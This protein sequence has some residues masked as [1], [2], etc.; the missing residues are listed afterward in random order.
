MTKI[1][2]NQKKIDDKETKKIKYDIAVKSYLDGSYKSVRKCAV[3]NQ[4]SHATLH[5]LIVEGDDYKGKK[6]IH[7]SLINLCNLN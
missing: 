7:L 2:K 3:A 4:V 1:R 5:R 6:A